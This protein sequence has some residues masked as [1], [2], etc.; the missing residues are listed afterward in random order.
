MKQEKKLRFFNRRKKNE[1]KEPEK[2]PLEVEIFKIF[3][4][5]SN[6]ELI[7]ISFSSFQKQLESIDNGQILSLCNGTDDFSVSIFVPENF[8]NFEKAR[9]KLQ[10]LTG[11]EVLQ[12]P[13]KKEFLQEFLWAI[14]T[15]EVFSSEDSGLFIATGEISENIHSAQSLE[16]TH[17]KEFSLGSI[18]IDDIQDKSFPVSV[19][20]EKLLFDI[21]DEIDQSYLCFESTIMID[22]SE[23]QFLYLIKQKSKLT[24]NLVKTLIKNQQKRL[25]GLLKIPVSIKHAG[26]FEMKEQSNQSDFML[27]GMIHTRISEFPYKMIFPKKFLALFP[28]YTCTTVKGK[29]LQINKEI[30]RQD[31]NI[32]HRTDN[33]FLFSDYLSIIDNRD[34]NLICQNFFLSNTIG[35]DEIRKLFYYKIIIGEK[36]GIYRI[37]LIAK[38]QFV[39]HLPVRLKESFIQSK[40]YSQSYEDLLDANESILQLIY[41]EL[42]EGKLLLSYKSRFI[43]DKELGSKEKENKTRRL[44]KLI[45]DHRYINALSHLDNKKVQ[46]LFSNMQNVLIVDTFIYQTDELVKLKPYFSTRR[47]NELKEDINFT[48][49][50][51]KSNQIDMNRICDSIEK[52]NKYIR[53]F[54]SKDKKREKAE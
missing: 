11:F 33:K 54:I 44:R 3:S 21:G 45:G 42:N 31:F 22:R 8:T 6:D 7:K 2:L 14:S 40:S 5:N 50:K 37:P 48:Q 49:G 32:F 15:K 34:L 20:Y 1:K 4:E 10:E 51:I 39:T 23:Y 13:F 27:S 41:K 30:F 17:S 12:Y 25:D 24:A 46:I 35:G 28:E 18:L 53:D 38:E 9:Q 36:A 29:I 16:V 43:L 52:F 47:F 19:S 26:V